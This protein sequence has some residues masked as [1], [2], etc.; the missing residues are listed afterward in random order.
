MKI[1]Y[2]IGSV[3]FSTVMFTQSETNSVVVISGLLFLYF[4]GNL[5]LQ[6]LNK[7][8]LQKYNKNF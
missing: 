8:L 6:N 2:G 1:F 3:F 7:F 4:C 5:L